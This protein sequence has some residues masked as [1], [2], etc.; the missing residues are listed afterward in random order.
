MSETPAASSIK[1]EG[2]GQRAVKLF[3]SYSHRDMKWMEH[4]L[5][6][7]EGFQYDQRRAS[8][9]LP[10]V[11]TWHDNLLTVENEWDD[12]IKRELEEMD[13]FVPLVSGP[14]FG[15]EYIQKIEL[16]RAKKRYLAGEILVVPI[17]IY[18]T[19]LREKCPFLH[20]LNLFPARDRTWHSYSDPYDAHR[21]IDDGLWQ[22]INACPRPRERKK[23]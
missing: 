5:P 23:P 2:H 9:L 10:Y 12:T 19:N 15:S 8:R 7:L 3:I 11:Y 4:L 6:V 14:V 21:L 20:R 22:A 1:P 16:K 17:V 13:I 18:N